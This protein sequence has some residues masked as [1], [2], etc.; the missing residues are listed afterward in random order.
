[1]PRLAVDDR[2]IAVPCAESDFAYS[3]LAGDAAV[4][5]DI[6]GKKYVLAPKSFS[7]NFCICWKGTRVCFVDRDNILAN[8]LEDQHEPEQATL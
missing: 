4:Y 1:M 2:F 7:K 8:I 6:D 3:D 5:S